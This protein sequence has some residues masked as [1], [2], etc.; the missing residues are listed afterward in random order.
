MNRCSDKKFTDRPDRLHYFD[1]THAR[2]EDNSATSTSTL[3][4]VKIYEDDADGS[5]ERAAGN[6]YV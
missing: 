5:S 4:L 1:L 3:C 6:K 2:L